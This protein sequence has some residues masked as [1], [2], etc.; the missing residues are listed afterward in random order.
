MFSLLHRLTATLFY[1]CGLLGFILLALARGGIG[2]NWILPLLSSS[3]LPFIA[4]T[5][6]YAG[7]S[8]YAALEKGHPQPRLL[9][10]LI[11]V[12]CIAL[13]IFFLVL[14]FGFPLH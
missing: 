10:F 1:V 9:A 5:L 12:P 8:A 2:S 3:D 14:N 13:F 11:A 6:S 4:I 7:M